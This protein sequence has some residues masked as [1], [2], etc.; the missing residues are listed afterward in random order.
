M[1]ENEVDSFD[2]YDSCLCGMITK[3]PFIGSSEIANDLLGIIH[4]DV[5]GPFKT[6][7]RNGEMYF[8]TFTDE[9]SRHGYVY[10]NKHKHEAFVMFKVFQ[11]EVENHLNKTIIVLRSNIG[12]E[13]LSDE[14]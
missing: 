11:S 14:F 6:M 3:A 8:I 12:R 1:K 10:L 4:T 7:S 5:C 2:I 9:L 13:C